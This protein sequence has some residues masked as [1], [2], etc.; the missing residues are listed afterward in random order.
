MLEVFVCG[1]DPNQYTFP[2]GDVEECVKEALYEFSESPP[3]GVFTKSII[4]IG[5]FV[6]H[7]G[8]ELRDETDA[9]AEAIISFLKYREGFCTVTVNRPNGSVDVVEITMPNGDERPTFKIVS[10]Y[11][12]A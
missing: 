3:H 1:L 10:Q 12:H 4:I 6:H 11:P 2:S 9:R 8:D 7:N 5:G